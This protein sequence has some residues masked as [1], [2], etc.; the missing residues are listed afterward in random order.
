MCT[1]FFLTEF[2]RWVRVRWHFRRPACQAT[3]RRLLRPGVAGAPP[4]QRCAGPASPQGAR[5]RLG[6]WPATSPAWAVRGFRGHVGHAVRCCLGPGRGRKTVAAAQQ[7]VP[8]AALCFFLPVPVA[9]S[10]SRSRFRLR[11]VLSGPSC[12]RQV[13]VLFPG[14]L[15]RFGASCPR[16]V[17][18]VSPA[19]LNCFS[20]P[21]C[22]RQ[23]VAPC[24]ALLMC[25][26][27]AQ[28][29]QQVAVL[30]PDV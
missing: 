14:A 26:S 6:A 19:V 7:L 23:V 29:P 16:S 11:A 5:R 15:F 18:V 8:L 9:P 22:T 25:F 17:V 1:K 13:A 2:R 24:P 10:R 30:C 27:R 12:S 20:G 21:S 4:G 28:G 3:A